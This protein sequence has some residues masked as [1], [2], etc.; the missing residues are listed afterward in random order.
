[1]TDR[2]MHG[3]EICDGEPEC[4]CRL[5]KALHVLHPQTVDLVRRFSDALAEK[6]L[7][8]EVKYGYSDGWRSPDWMEE[9]R[10]K[11]LEHVAKGDPRDV[12]A[13]CAFLWHHGEKTVMPPQKTA[14]EHFADEVEA[15][16]EPSLVRQ[17]AEKT[18]AAAQVRN[19]FAH[20]E[21]IAKP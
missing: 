11:L 3:C 19:Q 14:L 1:M 9:C 17:V 10:A 4:T 5:T 15:S 20:Y 21:E 8:A 6:L 2:I 18:G 7:A 16:G 13:Y 12:A